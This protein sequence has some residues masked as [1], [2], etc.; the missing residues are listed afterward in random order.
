MGSDDLFKKRKGAKKKRKESIR[1]RAPYR[2]LIVCEGGKTE[3]NYFEGI[4][5][6]VEAKYRDKIDVKNKIELEIKGTGRNTED[7]VD[8]TIKLRSLSEIPYGHTWVVF[9]KDDFTDE[10]F[11]NA[12][13]KAQNSDI[14]VAWSNE[15]IEL[16]F[17]LHFE[18]LHSAIRRY[19]YIEKLNEHFT[20]KSINNGKYHKNLNNIF[21]ILCKNG[22]I[23]EAIRRSEKLRK[24]YEEQGV[25]SEAN[26]NPCTNVD[27]LVEELLQYF[28]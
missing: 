26:M 6:K 28:E 14:D 12:I 1:E 23:K 10:Q 11:N 5:R 27:R 24:Y 13:R 8:Y 2:Y 9:D 17:V 22:N 20:A 18:Y 21:D 15:S 7:L 25:T 19:Q 4:K 3:P 16:W